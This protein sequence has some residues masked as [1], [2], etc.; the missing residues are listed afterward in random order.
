MS[1]PENIEKDKTVAD[2]LI[3]TTGWWIDILAPTNNELRIISK[4]KCRN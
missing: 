4:V 1:S 3:D 2:L